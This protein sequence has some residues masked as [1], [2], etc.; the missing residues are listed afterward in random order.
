[1]VETAPYVPESEGEE[2]TLTI[3]AL[4]DIH[5]RFEA[6][7]IVFENAITDMNDLEDIDVGIIA[8]DLLKSRSRDDSFDWFLETRSRANIGGWFEIA[9]NHGARSQP[10]F[11]HY[12]PIP[13]YY[14]VE[15][16]N[17]LFLM[18]SD[19]STKSR[20]D[21]SD[22]GFNWWRR[23][24]MD[25]QDKIIVTVT[26]A[27]LTN[28]GLLGSFFASRR[29]N[30]STRFEEVLKRYKVALWLSGHTHLPQGISG[31]VSIKKE[32]GNTCFVNVSSISVDGFL[33]S[34]SRL[35]VFKNGRKQVWIRSRNHTKR[36]FEP[37]L[38]IP[39]ELEKTFLW[40]RT[41]PRLILPAGF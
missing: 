37:N 21:I 25:N 14:G 4:S 26:H 3:W 6:E 40:D 28:S 11:S 22:T 35:F 23:M 17:I 1:M 39:L 27:Q 7:R 24:V 32:L 20:T 13:P 8:G 31:T 38:D 36:A 19:T 15:I 9:G 34:Q 16:G 30:D 33:D 2:Q 41:P 12:F 29:I 5:P 18:L 10:L